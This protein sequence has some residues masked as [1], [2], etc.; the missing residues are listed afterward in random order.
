MMALNTTFTL[1][2]QII[3]IDLKNKINPWLTTTNEINSKQR[4]LE[5][6]G[7]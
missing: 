7:Y 6:I 4:A 1:P 3:L 5:L 2:N